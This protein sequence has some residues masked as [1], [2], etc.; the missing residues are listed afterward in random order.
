MANDK[1]NTPQSADEQ[2]HLPIDEQIR[3]AKGRA[4]NQPNHPP[5]PVDDPEHGDDRV[6][7]H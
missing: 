6:L 3:I 7:K 1:I 2:E 4:D 5:R